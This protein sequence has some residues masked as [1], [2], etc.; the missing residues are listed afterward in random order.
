MSTSLISRDDVDTTVRRRA[1]VGLLALVVVT[2]LTAWLTASTTQASAGEIA[3]IASVAAFTATLAALA[4][5]HAV[6]KPALDGMRRTERVA[7]RRQLI[8]PLTGLLSR[9][10]LYKHLMR[11]PPS[12]QATLG[13]LMIDLNR[14]RMLS[15][16]LGPQQGD[17]LLREVAKRLHAVLQDS[18]VAARTGSD[19]F[20]VA[21]T[22]LASVPAAESMARNLLRVVEGTQQVGTREV[23]I[24]ATIGMALMQA[25]SSSVDDLF[26]QAEAALRVA[27]RGTN[28]GANAPIRVFN[29]TMLVDLKQRLDFEASLRAAVQAQAF[30]VV[31]QPIVKTDGQSVHAVEA[32]MRW[33]PKGLP[34]I[35]P[36]RFIPVLEETGLIVPMGLWVLREACRKASAWIKRG[37][38]PFV[39]SVNVS[40]IQFAEPDFVAQVLA[41]IEST[42]WPANLLQLEVTEGLLLDPSAELKGKLE[43]LVDAGVR[44][45]LD[46]FGMGYSSMAYL[47]RF[48]LHS[49][50]IDRMFVQD[51]PKQAK[52]TAIVR[53][54]VELAHALGL[55]V[56]VEG[57]EFADQHTV[58]TTLGC[59][60][61]QGFYFALPMAADALQALLLEAAHPQQGASPAMDW[62]STLAAAFE[63]V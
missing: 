28:A 41:V 33:T 9:G 38:D 27:K 6:V 17:L 18:D 35:S 50:K 15:G 22:Q 54:M 29:P 25:T 20:M 5:W 63:T 7:K 43:R 14:F 48:R 1:L 47:K 53:A 42:A 60:S 2:T 32:L 34:A 51:V 23:R 46:D 3:L 56:T 11:L 12:S 55:H 36:A 26:S 45:A 61:L 30:H 24:T 40:P 13:L 57:V 31:Y 10:G 59:D 39:L 52:D 58:L 16:S 49:V 8:D 19:V 44:I 21:S 62:S 4:L 37:A